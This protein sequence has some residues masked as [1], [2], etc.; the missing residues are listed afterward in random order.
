ME[1]ILSVAFGAWIIVTA[2]F[3]KKMCNDNGKGGKK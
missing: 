1:I 2:L 3:Y